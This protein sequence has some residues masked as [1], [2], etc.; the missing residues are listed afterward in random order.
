MGLFVIVLKPTIHLDRLV[1]GKDRHSVVRFLAK[2]S[3]LEAGF[4]DRIVGEG[5]L[6]G[7]QLLQADRIRLRLLQP[8]KKPFQAT[9]DRVYVPGGNLQ[10]L[11]PISGIGHCDCIEVEG[12]AVS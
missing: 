2:D 7:L 1:T 3:G 12:R 11:G 9:A 8:P 10:G 6:R 5:V 4:S